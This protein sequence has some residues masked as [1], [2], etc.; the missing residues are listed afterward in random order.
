MKKK[1]LFQPHGFTLVEILVVLSLIGILA[2]S[3]LALI[4]PVDQF[5]KARDAQRKSDLRE[6]QKALEIYYSD[7]SSYPASSVDYKITRTTS[8]GNISIN[9]GDLWNGYMEKVPFDPT[10]SQRYV[11]YSTGQEF[12]LYARLERAGSDR[13]ACNAGAACSKLGANPFPPVDACGGMC[14]YGVTS[15]NTSP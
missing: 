5:Q 4:K 9:W 2:G 1:V 10:S 3:I 11:Y 7:A 6:I 14:N 12:Y 13:Q 8:G 15:P